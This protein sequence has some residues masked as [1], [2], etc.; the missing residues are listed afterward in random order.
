MEGIYIVTEMFSRVEKSKEFSSAWEIRLYI[1]IYRGRGDNQAV[2]RWHFIFWNLIHTHFL[3]ASGYLLLLTVW[4]F[5][6]C[7]QA[8]WLSA[9]LC[10]L[11]FFFATISLL[12][13]P[14]F[15]RFLI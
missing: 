5:G 7:W 3:I 4:S 10:S 11:K 15:G 2:F 1:T 14:Y 13:F 8:V 12:C 6:L 9:L